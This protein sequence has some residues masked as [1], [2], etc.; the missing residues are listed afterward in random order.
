VNLWTVGC[1]DPRLT[2]AS[3]V[4]YGHEHCDHGGDKINKQSRDLVAPDLSQR[5]KTNPIAKCLPAL[6]QSHLGKPDCDNVA[7]AVADFPPNGPLGGVIRTAPSGREARL[8]R[9][10]NAPFA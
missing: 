3:A 7:V 10:A 9:P 8:A 4:P 1:A 6:R 2:V 5:A